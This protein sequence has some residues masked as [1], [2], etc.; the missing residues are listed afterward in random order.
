MVE[1]MVAVGAVIEDQY[2]RILL[3][4]HVPEREG[5]W[6]GKWICP[7]G[8]LEPGETIREGIEREVMEE[9]N[10]RIR[11]TSPLVPFERI[12]KAG[13]ETK[14]HV[15]YIDF[16]AELAGGQLRLDSDVGEG[17][18]VGKDELSS[19]WDELH[20]DTQRLLRLAGVV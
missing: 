14:M 12:V 18:W 10:L 6:K 11:L 8:R 1:I 15:V 3:V 4:R 17:M 2:G 5:F 7:G 13:D 20:E 9:T 16:L 19:M